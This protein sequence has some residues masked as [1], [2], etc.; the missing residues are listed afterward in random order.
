MKSSLVDRASAQAITAEQASHET[1]TRGCGRLPRTGRRTHHD[2][3][4]TAGTLRTFDRA[5]R[6]RDHGAIATLLS[7]DTT[8]ALHHDTNAFVLPGA[9]NAVRLLLECGAIVREAHRVE[10]RA[11][12]RGQWRHFNRNGSMDGWQAIAALIG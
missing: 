12:A 7:E 11:G 6:K 2:R 4:E 8:L 1:G 5:I 9:E 3:H 10:A